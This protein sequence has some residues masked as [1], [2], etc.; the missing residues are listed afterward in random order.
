MNSLRE[1]LGNYLSMR[2]ALGFTLL[3]SGKALFNFVAFAELNGAQYI[4]T[5]LALTWAQQ[6]AAAK[7]A[8]WA[9]RLGYVRMFARY[10]SAIDS[11]TE[12]PP[13][14]LLPHSPT[15]A[16]PYLYSER[17]VEELMAAALKLPVCPNWPA[18]SLL[19][20]QTY[21]CL[22][23]LL[24]V[25]GMRISEAV[26]LRMQDV[27]W[28]TG[29]LTIE[30]AKHG[31]SRMVPLHPSTV[32]ALSSYKTSRDQYLQ[33]Q[34]AACFFINKVGASLDHG[35]VRRTFY[36][37]SRQTGLRGKRSKKGPR[38][39]DFRHRFAIETLV[40]WYRNGEDVE[41]KLPVLSTYLGHV[42]VSDTYW[43]LTA[44]PELMGRAVAC[45]ER[46]WEAKP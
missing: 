24:S 22:I 40:N 27:D 36:Q 16:R 45:L 25:T 42:H 38:I 17:E 7:P 28:S 21:Y 44:Y 2:R 26:N 14:D 33:G 46:R 37:L 9:A 18:A 4:T 6:P 41:R 23:G 10:L 43:Y 30:G 29:V 15:R 11:R 8:T 32:T 5:S 35:T 31:K 12:V 19:K 34:S 39:H 1:S 13:E 20:R 3:R